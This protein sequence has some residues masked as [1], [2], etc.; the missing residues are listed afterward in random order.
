MTRALGTKCCMPRTVRVWSGS[1]SMGSD[2]NVQLVTNPFAF[3]DRRDQS[4]SSRRYIPVWRE[5]VRGWLWRAHHT[6]TNIQLYVR[7]GTKYIRVEIGENV[8][9]CTVQ[10]GS[11]TTMMLRLRRVPLRSG[12]LSHVAAVSGQCLNPVVCRRVSRVPAEEAE[13]TRW[14]RHRGHAAPAD[15]PAKRRTRAES[16]G[17]RRTAHVSVHLIS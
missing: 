16:S 14:R 7:V 1:S 4:T 5:C 3:I 2:L 17:E 9:R 11:Y 12:L 8:C 15:W 13:P 6:H 10:Q